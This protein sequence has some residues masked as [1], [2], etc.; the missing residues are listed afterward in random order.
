MSSITKKI[1]AITIIAIGAILFIVFLKNI[2]GALNNGRIHHEIGGLTF[3]AYDELTVIE[4][5]EFNSLENV[6]LYS[7]KK[8]DH[9]TYCLVAELNA[10]SSSIVDAYT[11]ALEALLS[12]HNIDPAKVKMDDI[13]VDAHEMSTVFS[14]A[15]MRKQALGYGFLRLQGNKIESL[16]LIPV[17]ER[18]PEDY[19]IKFKEVIHVKGAK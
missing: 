3:Y 6:E 8:E 19:I 17:T 2:K 14:Y 13:T 10:D 16:W 9:V 1:L 4:S 5:P 18:F 12:Y 7:D 11:I 15:I